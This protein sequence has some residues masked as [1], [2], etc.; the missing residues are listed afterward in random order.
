M[1]KALLALALAAFVTLGT[2]GSLSA[3]SQPA[4]GS[5]YTTAL[6]LRLGYPLG[7]TLKHFLSPQA[8][9]EGIAGVGYGFNLTGLYEYHGDF[10]GAP[11][12]R[13]LAG[14]GLSFYSWPAWGA[15]VGL[16]GILGLDYKFDSAPVNLSLDWLPAFY[17]TGY[18]S[19]TGGGGAFSVRYTF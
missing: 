18:N 19:F 10:S 6:G 4:G 5:G 2:A 8:A 14:G 7:V 15:S 12:L 3:Q 9:L 17:F 1:K 16:A 13:W 11:G